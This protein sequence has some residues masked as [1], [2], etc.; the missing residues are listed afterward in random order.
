[1]IIHHYY[2]A[3]NPE[4]L[5]VSCHAFFSRRPVLSTRPPTV[6]ISILSSLFTRHRKETPM[7][8]TPVRYYGTTADPNHAFT[9]A[10]HD[11]LL[12]ALSGT[13]PSAGKVMIFGSL[14]YVGTGEIIV[15][16]DLHPAPFH[17]QQR[18]ISYSCSPTAFTVQY[19]SRSYIDLVHRVLYR[20]RPCHG[21]LCAVSAPPDY[22]GSSGN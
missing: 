5:W 3:A 11:S 15:T 19:C 7:K 16:D 6:I 13:L 21:Q 22:R 1:M 4:L 9:G 18:A 8:N 17:L 12:R 2:L 20:D 14:I 10:V